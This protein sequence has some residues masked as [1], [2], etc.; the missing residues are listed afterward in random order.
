M[1]R[2]F[3][4]FAILLGAV[5]TAKAQ[6]EDIPE[7]FFKR[8]IGIVGVPADTL[9]ERMNKWLATNELTAYGYKH[10]IG[11]DEI[12][13]KP[14]SEKSVYCSIDAPNYFR[15]KEDAYIVFLLTVRTFRY[16]ASVI[17]DE[18]NCMRNPI[19]PHFYG[20]NGVL[21]RECY[22][23]RHYIAGVKLLDYLS[24][25]FS[26]QCSSLEAYLKR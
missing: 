23:Y 26:E 22:D 5:F 13:R 2:F 3:L 10:I 15:G 17:M 24:D 20:R 4:A 11:T 9:A 1:K 14:R 12:L 21:F 25:L 6:E 19:L 16:G 18:I 7:I 8:T